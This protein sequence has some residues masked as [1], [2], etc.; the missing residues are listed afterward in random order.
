MPRAAGYSKK[1]ADLK[2]AVEGIFDVLTD[3]EIDVALEAL[4]HVT[5][6]FRRATRTRCAVS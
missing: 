5:E 3:I 1:Q 6:E 4:T 2:R